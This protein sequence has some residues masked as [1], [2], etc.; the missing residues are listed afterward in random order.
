MRKF[1]KKKD[2]FDVNGKYLEEYR[3]TDVLLLKNKK[4]MLHSF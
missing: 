1:K 4:K 2:T 3:P